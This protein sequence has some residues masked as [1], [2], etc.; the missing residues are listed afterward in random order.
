MRTIDTKEMEQVGGGCCLGWWS[1]KSPKS[2]AP[3]A[4]APKACAP[5]SCTPKPSAC[6][7]PA[8]VPVDPN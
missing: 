6:D 5:K 2:C 8:D 1:K 7:K 4:C 3:K